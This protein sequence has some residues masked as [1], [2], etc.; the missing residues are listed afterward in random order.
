MKEQKITLNNFESF[1]DP[2]I[3][4]RGLEYYQ[5]QRV[6]HL[7]KVDQGLWLA[8]VHGQHDYTV[9][10]R[11]HRSVIKSWEC[12][13]PFEYGSVC[14]HV[15][16]VL[17]EM[18]E[19]QTLKKMTEDQGPSARNSQSPAPKRKSRQDHIEEIFEKAGIDELQKFLRMQLGR[20]KEVRYEFLSYF[21]DLID[22]DMKPKYKRLVADIIKAS[23]DNHGFID[24][25]RSFEF[26]RRIDGLIGK[27]DQLIERK[28]YFESI[29]ICQSV[30]EGLL[31][32]IHSMDDSSGEA[33]ASL[34]LAFNIMT[35]ATSHLES[36][37]F[38]DELFQYCLR[39]YAVKKYAGF[40]FEIRF[41]EL[42]SLLIRT[43]DQEKDFF[44][45]IEKELNMLK[46]EA[47][48]E[49]KYK[50]LLQIKMD[51][52]QQRNR[53]AEVHHILET[54]K[55]IPEFRESL[56]DEAIK[57]GDHQLARDLIQEGIM[58]ARKKK[59]PGTEYQWMDKLLSI[60]MKEKD[61]PRIRELA[62]IMYFDN[63]TEYKKYYT[64]L[65]RSFEADEWTIKVDE[66][67]RKIKGPMERGSGGNARRLADIFTE[68]GYHDR[69]LTLLKTN[70]DNF[71]FVFSNLHKLPSAYAE[72]IPALVRPG[73]DHIAS[74]AG[75]S[76]YKELARFLNDISELPG[77][78]DFVSTYIKTIQ[79]RYA[80]R[81]A[82]LRILESKLPA[83]F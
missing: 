49:W 31:E 17:H 55:E 68:E 6:S 72:E 45:M 64:V 42:A 39:H 73:L 46:S 48:G 22:E 12:D 35:K 47:H 56:V 70:N 25:R 16:A 21:A 77:G 57:K 65:K 19:E 75:T 10:I 3:L 26:A 8:S 61:I 5:D 7:Q 82:M 67:I 60:A 29:I 32:A 44:A 34:E 51:Y 52:L 58:I 23:E 62:E 38:K 4:E 69:L 79:S 54:N 1:F 24:Y 36:P 37:L 33:G 27:A 66:L 50:S 78:K 40:G 83:Y 74:V 59:H 80:N 15:V 18:A 43:P 71:Y 14:K 63:H 76:R 11:T 9:T 28:N 20:N 41:L 13:C 81:P 30:L 53:P 2:V